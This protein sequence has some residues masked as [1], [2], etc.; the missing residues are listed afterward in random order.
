MKCTS[1]YIAL[2][3]SLMLLLLPACS[4]HGCDPYAEEL[5]A[6][7]AERIEQQLRAN[8]ES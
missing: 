6:A 8:V 1:C 2:F 3:F 7:E 4:G 5:E